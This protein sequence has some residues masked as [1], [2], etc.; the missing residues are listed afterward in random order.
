MLDETVSF[1]KARLAGKKL[2][3]ALIIYGDRG[4]RVYVSTKESITIGT[5]LLA[6]GSW[7]ADGSYIA[8]GGGDP[9]TDFQ[10]LVFDWGVMSE[11]LREN[12][13]GNVI[14]R[15]LRNYNIKLLNRQQYWSK[16]IDRER[17]LNRDAELVG[18]YLDLPESNQTAFL[19]MKV[20]GITLTNKYCILELEER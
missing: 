16:L 9:I 1:K 18:N 17:I 11:E 14:E 3:L 12:N 4:N 15:T 5:P 13:F 6:D 19:R 20:V 10:P 7:I 2:K 8:D